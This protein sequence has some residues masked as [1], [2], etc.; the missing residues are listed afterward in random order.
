MN[1]SALS[2]LEKL[3]EAITPAARQH[4]VFG[5]TPEQAQAELAAKKAAGEISENDHVIVISW[6]SEEA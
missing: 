4:I 3:E 6:M 2:R 5:D 1:R